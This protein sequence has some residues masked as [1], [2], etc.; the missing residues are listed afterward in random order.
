MVKRAPASFTIPAETQP[1]WAPESRSC[2]SSAPIDRLGTRSAAG[3]I[4]VKGTAIATSM[5][6]AA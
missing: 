3:A 1:V 4:K 5:P 6:G 2:T